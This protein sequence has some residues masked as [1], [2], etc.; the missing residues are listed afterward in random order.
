MR[1]GA[2]KSLIR[3]FRAAPPYLNAQVVDLPE[4]GLCVFRHPGLVRIDLAHQPTHIGRRCLKR[5][6]PF[7]DD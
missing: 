3:G 4:Q 5:K 6:H 2:E 7:L 1:S